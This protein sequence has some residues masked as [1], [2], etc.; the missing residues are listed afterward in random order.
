MEELVRTNDPVLISFLESLMKDA[1]IHHFIADHTMSI[2]D[3]SIGAIPR[4]L[5]VESDRADEARQIISD[6]GLSA[7]LRDRKPT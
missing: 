4:R 6:A 3:G 2:L 1:G 7:E 5:M